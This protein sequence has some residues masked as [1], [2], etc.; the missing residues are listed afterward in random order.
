[1]PP[2]SL[3]FKVGA[4]ALAIGVV[5]V[6]SGFVIAGTAHPG[7]APKAPF[8]VTGYAEAGGTTAAE[9]TA[10]AKALTMVG[11]DGVNLT[12]DANGIT[13]VDPSA[14]TLL[15]QSH[16]LGKKAELLFGN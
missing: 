10:S 9:V 3:R 6:A 12:E 11:V 4:I 15:A 5:T 8:T 1:M 2:T 14:L 16:K 13:A 7:P